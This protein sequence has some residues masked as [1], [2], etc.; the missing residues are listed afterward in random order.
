MREIMD[1]RIPTSPNGGK[2]LNLFGTT[3]EVNKLPRQP[4]PNTPVEKLMAELDGH[5]ECLDEILFSVKPS[6]QQKEQAVKAEINKIIRPFQQ[7]DPR[8]AFGSRWGE[9]TA[10][11]AAVRLGW[12]KKKVRNH[13]SRSDPSPAK[14]EQGHA[15]AMIISWLN[16]KLSPQDKKLAQ[17]ARLERKLHSWIN[18]ARQSGC[19]EKQAVEVVKCVLHLQTS[20]SQTG[21][22]PNLSHLIKH[23]SKG[24]VGET[25]NIVHL[26][27]L[28]RVNTTENGAEVITETRGFSNTHGRVIVSQTQ[29][30]DELNQILSPISDIQVPLRLILIILDINEHLFESKTVDELDEKTDRFINNFRPLVHQKWPQAEVMKMSEL[31]GL[32]RAIDI[33]E[34]SI[35]Q[36]ESRHL[37]EHLDPITLERMSEKTRQKLCRRDVPD[38]QKNLVTAKRLSKQEI[39]IETISGEMVSTMIEDPTVTQRSSSRAAAINFLK[40]AK[41]T[42]AHP[43]F[44]FF[45]TRRKKV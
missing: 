19:S 25:I 24:V 23:L 37:D 15:S 1:N 42:G 22:I 31:I 33:L 5:R 44:L 34:T 27:C 40:G 28:P 10:E 45:M 6:Q 35:W 9:I 32:D 39:I 36:R 29:E 17:K 30:L 26:H 4:E 13:L 20:Q 43:P 3:I 11:I 18:L 14:T 41:R 12:T 7:P 2:N 21:E 38:E 16:E 8:N